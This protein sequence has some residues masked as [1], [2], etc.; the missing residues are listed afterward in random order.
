MSRRSPAWANYVSRS[1]QV[2][3]RQVARDRAER[4]YRRELHDL[5]RKREAYEPRRA[6]TQDD[7]EAEFER[8]LFGGS[9]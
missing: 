2:S 6:L 7:F 8:I 3:K 4:A 5:A 9:K 1:T